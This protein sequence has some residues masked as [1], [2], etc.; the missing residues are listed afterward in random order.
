MEFPYV[1]GWFWNNSIYSLN[2][3]F[4][5]ARNFEKDLLVVTV[6][7]VA[8]FINSSKYISYTCQSSSS[9]VIIKPVTIIPLKKLKL[10][11]GSFLAFGF[12]CY[13]K[14]DWNKKK[15]LL[16]FIFSKVF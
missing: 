14:N 11:S 8:T 5:I 6:L 13:K 9:F 4:N 3:N 2:G 1:P 7:I 15:L 16:Q 10:N 12:P